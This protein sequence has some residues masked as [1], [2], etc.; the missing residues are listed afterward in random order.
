MAI[1]EDGASKYL[2]S[3]SSSEYLSYLL[4]DD[5]QPVTIR[6]RDPRL[7]HLPAELIELICAF[8]FG[9]P[10]RESSQAAFNDYIPNHS[11]ALEL[12]DIYY[13]YAS[14]QFNPVTREEFDRDILVPLYTM[15]DEPSV[16]YIKPHQL[17]LFFGILCLGMIWKE[18]PTVPLTQTRYYALACGAISLEPISLKKTCTTVQA[19]FTINRAL[20][21]F[22]R[23]AMEDCWLLHGMNVRVAQAMALQYDPVQFGLNE[24]E[25]Q[26]RR[27]L[28]WELFS[29]DIWNGFVMGRIPGL[30]AAYTD[31]KFPN[32]EGGK[33]RLSLEEMDFH[34][35][36]YRYTIT[37]MPPSLRHA[38][39]PGTLPYE[40]LLQLDK[41]IRTFPTPRHLHVSFQEQGPSATSWS[42]NP[43]IAMQQC[44]VIFLK[45]TNLMY[46][47][48]PFFVTAIRESPA[49]PLSHKYAPS[50]LAAYRSACRICLAMKGL[51]YM[52]PVPVEPI[53][54]FWSQVFSSCVVLAALVIGSP[55]CVIAEQCLL[56][57]EDAYKFFEEGSARCRPPK[58][59][60]SFDLLIL[61]HYTRSDTCSTVLGLIIQDEAACQE[62]LCQP[63][64]ESQLAGSTCKGRG[65]GR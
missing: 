38:L 46:L 12:V 48:R 4:P 62:C 26:R 14:W 9:L 65:T 32:L 16:A 1:N 25:V 30:Q 23:G 13:S 43:A 60:V 21:H 31:C 28:F 42:E 59:M 55:N 3:S 50:V 8:P 7:L 6:L 2:G 24:T 36:V 44:N 29:W 40:L 17:A 54:Y 49:N 45:E 57:F 22:V 56:E 53:W 64:Y 58:C 52:H 10:D 51:H 41:Q 37:M 27:L 61:S 39:T 35:W 18:G 47:H 63:P 5:D 11:F 20:H 33:Q 15:D 34:S 19:L